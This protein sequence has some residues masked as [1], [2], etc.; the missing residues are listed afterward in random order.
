VPEALTDS[1][2]RR[3]LEFRSGLRRFVRWSEEAASALGVTPAQHQLLL[4]VRGH[5]D[6]RGPTVGEVADYLL[7]RHH[8]AGE[9]VDRAAAA[10]L[11][12]RA[13]DDEDARVVRVRLTQTGAARLSALSS[14]HLQELDRLVPRMARLWEGV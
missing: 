11:V 8:S 14:A 10:G 1:E 3:L 12:A 2:Y 4:A 13:P 5:D 7:L 9:L 6:S